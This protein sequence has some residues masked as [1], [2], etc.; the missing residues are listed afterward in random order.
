MSVKV[1]CTNCFKALSTPSRMVIYSYLESEEKAR[2]SEIVQVAKLRQPT[3]SYHLKE[4]EK[5]GLLSSER[6]G[7]EVYYSVSHICPYDNHKC[8][9]D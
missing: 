9:L 3:V 6:K 1:K 4:M 5:C 2:V 8:V 7:K